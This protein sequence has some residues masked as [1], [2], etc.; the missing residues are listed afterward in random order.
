MNVKNQKIISMLVTTALFVGFLASRAIAE[1]EV[2]NLNVV[3]YQPPSRLIEYLNAN[4]PEG[5]SYNREGYVGLQDADFVIYFMSDFRNRYEIPDFGARLLDMGDEL[6]PDTTVVN[7]S[8]K[9]GDRFVYLI[10][11]ATGKIGASEE[12]IR[13]NTTNAV[14]ALTLNFKSDAPLRIRNC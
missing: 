7:R 12:D 5:V 14:M 11:V 4:A 1:E 9:H 3:T 8:V 6:S 10:Y 2:V 13:C